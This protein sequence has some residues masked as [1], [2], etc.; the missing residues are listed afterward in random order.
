M[1]QLGGSGH[2]EI[3]GW[4][5]SE[6]LP[7]SGHNS[8]FRLDCST[9]RDYTRVI[10]GHVPVASTSASRQTSQVASQTARRQSGGIGTA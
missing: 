3:P 7:I 8:L 5:G 1:S 9:L 6:G 4:A 2:R 10:G